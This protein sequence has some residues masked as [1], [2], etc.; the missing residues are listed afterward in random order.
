MSLFFN[1]FFK[2]DQMGLES[3]F[4]K[5]VAELEKKYLALYQPIYNKVKI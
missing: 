4:Q 2:D 1:P 5:E 3:E